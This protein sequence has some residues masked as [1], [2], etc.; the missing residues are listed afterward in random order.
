[1]R[2]DAEKKKVQLDG[3]EGHPGSDT[4]DSPQAGELNKDEKELI[5]PGMRNAIE[6]NE[7]KYRTIFENTSD[8][9]LY[10]NKW[11]TIIDVNSRIEEVFG[12]KREEVKGR[13][14]AAFGA[15]SILLRDLPRIIGLFKDAVRNGNLVYKSL[16]FEIKH[17]KGHK[18]II[19]ETPRFVMKDGKI[20]GL[21]VILR[22]ITER[23]K[24]VE[25]LKQ[26]EEKFRSLTLNIPGMVYR[27]GS[28]WYVDFVVNSES[29]CGYSAQ[30]F[31]D[32]RIKWLD[33]IHP[34]DKDRIF[35]EGRQL[36]RTDSSIVQEYRIVTKS[37]EVRWV[38]DRK[39]SIIEG[40]GVVSNVN[41]VVFDMTERKK[42]EEAL[43]DERTKLQTILEIMKSGVSIRD[44]KYNIVYENEYMSRFFGSNIGQKCYLAYSKC[45]AVC[46]GCPVELAYKDGKSHTSLK[47]LVLPSG[48]IS[49]WES[50]ASPFRDA[51][52]NIISCLVVNVNIT[53]RK[54]AQEELNRFREEMARA[55]QLASIGTLSAIAAHELTQ[56]LTVIR[57]L[58]ENAITKVQSGK[59]AASVTTELKDSLTEITN[60]TSVI[61]RLR[62]FARKSAGKNIGKVNL[63]MVAGK[64]VNLLSES[65]QRS[66][67][68]LYLEGMDD[69]PSLYL[70]ENDLEQMFFALIANSIQAARNK[71][72]CRL[73]IS[74]RRK[75]EFIEVRFSDNCGGIEAANLDRIFEPFFTTKPEGQGTGLGLCIVKDVVARAG[76]Q[77]RV[78]SEFGKGSTF[79]VTLSM[80]N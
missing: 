22:D 21:V 6:Q 11:G 8:A 30:D 59:T 40:T 52:G 49:Y 4:A 25:S 61:D 50:T 62:N 32:R 57:L 69:L 2:R 74:A 5:H 35:A 44:L 36:I 55:E 12:Y 15:K 9:V 60:I 56:P 23:K 19:E 77:I 73:V 66:A 71:K 29:I 1:M 7:D 41:G 54:K 34:L 17:K 58:I 13:H 79:I 48:E 70:N 39:S 42:M 37:G 53:E 3:Q 78:E 63:G 68:V 65:A 24:S 51:A 43:F 26:S 28:D 76:G 80:N 64:I 46:S 75:G 10:L 72:N 45:E 47:T 38:E 20:D 31:Y 27:A 33:I 67:F 16:E 18:I 14:F